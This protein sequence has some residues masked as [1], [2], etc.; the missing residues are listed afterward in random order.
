MKTKVANKKCKSIRSRLYK[1]VS[2]RIGLNA[3]WV[4]NH[5]VGCSRCRQRLASVGRVNLA[6]SLIKSQPHNLALLMRANTQAV[7]VLKHSLRNAP[8]AQKLKVMLPEPKLRERCQK[9]KHSLANVAACIAI[10]LLMKVAVF[11]S[12]DRF[13]R[14]GRKVVKQYY[15]SRVG[16]EMAN[17][18]FSA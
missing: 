4:Q 6:L 3:D 17:E 16:E 15:A 9:Y 11:S 2:K 1:A 10:L 8:R 12:M 5:I 14:Q 18:I 13:Q 7:G